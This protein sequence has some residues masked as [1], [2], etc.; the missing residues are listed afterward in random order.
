VLGLFLVAFFFKR[1][2]GTAVFWGAIAAQLL[3]F[4][5]YATLSISYLWYNL[6]GCAAC[7][8][9]AATLQVAL[10]KPINHGAHG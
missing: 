6:I 2:G 8:L 3:V 4:V 5:L 9:F 7:V 1:V 10:P